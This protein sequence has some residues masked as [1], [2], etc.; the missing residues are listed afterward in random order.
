[1]PMRAR[2]P[3]ISL[4]DLLALAIVVGAGV[5]LLATGTPAQDL[6]TGVLAMSTL[7]SRWQSSATRV[8]GQ[9]G[10]IR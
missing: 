9:P 5:L 2:I 3:E 7:Y 10:E 6:A 8:S 1:M 4:Y